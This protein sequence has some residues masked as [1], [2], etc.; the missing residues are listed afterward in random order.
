M[1]D[2]RDSHGYWV[3][4]CPVISTAHVTAEVGE[5]MRNAPPHLDEN[6]G[7]LYG[8]YYAITMHGAFIACPDD[9]VLDSEV[10][11]CLRDCFRW[12]QSEGLEWIRFDCEG[13]FIP[14]LPEYDW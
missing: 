1:T 2:K 13:D 8:L 6:P 3:M 7:A 10:P 9:T 11:K 5:A 12:A 4:Q 14:E